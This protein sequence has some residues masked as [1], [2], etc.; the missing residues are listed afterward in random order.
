MHSAKAIKALEARQSQQKQRLEL[1]ANLRY[2]V[3]NQRVARVNAS[4]GPRALRSAL[5]RERDAFY[6]PTRREID[7]V[8]GWNG[9]SAA[10]VVHFRYTGYRFSAALEA[11][12]IAIGS[13]T[14]VGQRR[15]L[16]P[17]GDENLEHGH[18][19]VGIIAREHSN[20][21]FSSTVLAP[22]DRGIIRPTSSSRSFLVAPQRAHPRLTASRV[23]IAGHGQRVR[24]RASGNPKSQRKSKNLT[25]VRALRYTPR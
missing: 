15:Q 1:S 13:S 20:C 18:A 12:R 11:Y 21:R 4:P 10:K 16:L 14:V 9:N 17:G 25:E 3:Q 7:A 2:H 24:R 8:W 22:L 5:R 19:A 23:D 6:A